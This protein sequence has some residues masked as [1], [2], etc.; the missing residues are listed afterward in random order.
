MLREVRMLER[1]PITPLEGAV[2][3]PIRAAG[4]AQARDTSE[5]KPTIE[6]KWSRTPCFWVREVEE[7][8]RKDRHGNYYWETVGE[9]TRFV[10]FDLQD[11]SGRMLLVPDRDLSAYVSKS[12]SQREGEAGRW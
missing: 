11:S 6:A 8:R 4:E 1:L 3:G 9:S 7:E 10:P 5:G 2:P 12:W